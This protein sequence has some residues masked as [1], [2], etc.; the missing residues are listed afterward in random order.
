[1]PHSVAFIQTYTMHVHT[2]G[3][4]KEYTLHIDT[5]I[6]LAVHTARLYCW[7]WKGIH[8]ASKPWIQIGYRSVFSLKCWIPNRIKWL[9]IWNTGGGKEYT[10]HVHTAGGGKVYSCCWCRKLTCKWRIK[11]WHRHLQSGTAGH[12]LV[13]H[14][15]AM[16]L[17]N[18][19]IS[20]L[21]MYSLRL[22]STEWHIKSR[23][24][25]TGCL[26]HLEDFLLRTHT[27]INRHT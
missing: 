4:G 9:R 12:G 25:I 5:S 11:V 6:L 24:T 23:E 1:M 13:R 10:Q 19:G 15:Q 17:K 26:R 7:W 2:V 3:G 8:P 27:G 22:F 21:Y 16:V 18:T 14:C 20:W